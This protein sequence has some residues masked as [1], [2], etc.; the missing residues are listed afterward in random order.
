M[1]HF[2]NTLEKRKRSHQGVNSF[3]IEPVRIYSFGLIFWAWTRL[4]N[5]RVTL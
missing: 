4:L 2:L 1:T 5:F 3:R